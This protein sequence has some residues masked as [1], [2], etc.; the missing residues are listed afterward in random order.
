MIVPLAVLSVVATVLDGISSHP[1]ISAFVAIVVLVV[2]AGIVVVSRRREAS[3]A[4]EH[5]QARRAQWAIAVAQSREIA[6]YH[7]MD[8]RAFE[9]ALA[10]LCTRDGCTGVEATGKAGDFGADVIAYSPNGRKVVLQA[11]RYGP[12]HK[13]GSQDMQR[14]GGTCFTYHQAA[15]AAVV[16]TS[17]FTRHAMDYA[18]KAGIRLVDVNALAAWASRTGPAP[19]H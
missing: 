2:V 15:I 11:K 8:S 5:E 18:T 4:A 13:V 6:Q 7:A 10:F 3:L 1:V 16:T 17:T 9:Q 19:W 14:F 12:T